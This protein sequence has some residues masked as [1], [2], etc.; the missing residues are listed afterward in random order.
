MLLLRCIV[1][2]GTAGACTL[3]PCPTSPLS[4]QARSL[5]GTMPHAHQL[6]VSPS[7]THTHTH[8]RTH[9]VHPSPHRPTNGLIPDRRR[10][11][12]RSCAP[13][14]CLRHDWFRALCSRRS[15]KQSRSSSSLLTLTAAL[16]ALREWPLPQ[17]SLH[18]DVPL[19]PSRVAQLVAS[20]LPTPVHPLVCTCPLR[21]PPWPALLLPPPQIIPL[22]TSMS[23]LS[24]GQ[25]HP[26]CFGNG[27]CPWPVA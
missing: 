1:V 18:Y 2:A 26:I 13:T 24:L 7:L 15:W 14:G 17:T 8:T 3:P 21:A 11:V 6:T 22:A 16:T 4:H 12:S 23:I 10:L 9:T 5:H 25:C 20:P 19:G 27:H